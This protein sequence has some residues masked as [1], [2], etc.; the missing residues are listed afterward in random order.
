LNLG[1]NK[2]FGTGKSTNIE[3]QDDLMLGKG[4]I[5]VTEVYNN[6]LNKGILGVRALGHNKNILSVS[7]TVFPQLSRF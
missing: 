5:D 3:N 7:L 6:N 1:W 2:N 4:D